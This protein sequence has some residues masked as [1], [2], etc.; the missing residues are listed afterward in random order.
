[1]GTLLELGMGEWF[2]DE[3]AWCPSY[4]ALRRNRPLPSGNIKDFIFFSKRYK[5]LR[6]RELLK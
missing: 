5:N 2:P 4:I 6:H 1:M 3:K